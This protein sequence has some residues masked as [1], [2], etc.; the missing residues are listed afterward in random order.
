MKMLDPGSVVRESEFANAAATG[1]FGE[2]LKAAGQRLLAGER[3]S[4]VMRED[5]VNRAEG[6]YAGMTD[7]HEQRMKVYTTLAENYGL[8]G[9]NVAIDLFPPETAADTI[10][11]L[12]EKYK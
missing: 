2:R 7:Q 9:R 6:L 1:S 5:F 10:D 8:E 11:E 12:L 4:D 3:L